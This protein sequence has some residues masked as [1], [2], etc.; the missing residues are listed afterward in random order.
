MEAPWSTKEDRFR[1]GVGIQ[2]Q[3]HEAALPS[4]RHL[5]ISTAYHPQT[6]GQSERANQVVEMYLRQFVNHRQ[7]DWASLLPLAEFAYNNGVQASTGKSP[8]Q[9]CY[10]FNPRLNVR[11]DTNGNVPNTD[12]HAEFLRQGH[13]EVKASLELANERIKHFY[14]QNHQA[15]E[16]IQI[17]DKVWLNHQNI[18][19]NRPSRK[20]SCHNPPLILCTAHFT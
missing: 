17:G 11:E 10:G 7:E 13:D 9:I 1:L 2:F 16:D 8:F 18:E 19:T 20:L 12:K 5:A 6:E 14:D 15:P 4:S 3:V